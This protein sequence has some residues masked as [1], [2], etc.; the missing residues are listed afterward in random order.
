MGVRVDMCTPKRRPKQAREGSVSASSTQATGGG[1]SSRVLGE[2]GVEGAGAVLTTV[3]TFLS[4]NCWVPFCI[5]VP[6]TV[7]Q[8]APSARGRREARR[9]LMM[10]CALACMVPVG[11]W[12]CANLPSP[13]PGSQPT[14]S[15]GNWPPAACL[16]TQCPTPQAPGNPDVR[17]P[18]L[19]CT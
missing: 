1:L 15:S 18:T 12:P 6:G 9:L 7:V 3:S 8:P 16:L 5:W 10:A 11:R 14:S 17:S 19:W 4:G 13:L 2:Q